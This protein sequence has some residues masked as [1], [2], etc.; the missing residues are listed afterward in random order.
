MTDNTGSPV[1]SQKLP[2]SHDVVINVDNDF[3]MCYI[4]L[5]VNGEM[6]KANCVKMT[7]FVHI[8]VSL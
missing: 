3:V 8:N 6:R 7:P 5:Y 1:S 4:K 2:L